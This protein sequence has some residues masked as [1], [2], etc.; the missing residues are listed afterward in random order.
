MTARFCPPF[1]DLPGRPSSLVAGDFDEDGDLDLAVAIKLDAALSPD[2]QV[3]VLKGNGLG[4]FYGE[5][6]F[7]DRD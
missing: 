5:R 6:V 3:V 2:N 1:I 7:H 4:G